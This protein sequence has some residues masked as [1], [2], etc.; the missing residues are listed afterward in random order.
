[1]RSSTLLLLVVS[2]TL[3]AFAQVS[4]KIG[5]SAP[6]VQRLVGES[7]WNTA[8][9]AFA[10]RPAIWLGLTLYGIGTVIWLVALSRTQLSQ[11]YPFVGLGFVLTSLFGVVL[12]SDAMGPLRLIGTALVV[13]GIWLIAR[14]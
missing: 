10:S 8:V 9:M 13:I 1:M 7:R 12:F 6:Q 14:S 3:S 11:A 4:F 2:V 5:V